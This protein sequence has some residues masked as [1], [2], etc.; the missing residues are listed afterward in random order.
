MIEAALKE[1]R[2]TGV[3]GEIPTDRVVLTKALGLERA[4]SWEADEYWARRRVDLLH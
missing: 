2:R 1:R 4:I 3:E